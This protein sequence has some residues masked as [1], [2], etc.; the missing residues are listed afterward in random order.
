MIVVIADD[1]SG[2]A[3][4]AGTAREAGLS[5]EVQTEFD[6]SSPAEV[7]AVDTDSRAS[8]EADAIAKVSAIAR[9]VV[10]A[11]PAWIYK[12]CD[13][14]LRG[15]VLAEC[16][17]IATVADKQRVLLI[18]ANPGRQRVIRDGR[19]LVSGV[20][21]DQS[22]FARDPQ[23]PARTADVLANL[24]EKRDGIYSLR[25]TKAPHADGVSIPDVWESL[26]L[27]ERARQ[28]GPETL[29]AGAME[30]FTAL[31]RRTPL[32]SGTAPEFETRSPLRL[33]A[34]GSHA[35]WAGTRVRECQGR[36]VPIVPMPRRIFEEDFEDR[37]IDQ[38]ADETVGAFAIGD[39]VMIA[40]GGEKISGLPPGRLDSRLADA[41]RR[42]LNRVTIGQLCLEGGAT[43]A[44]VLGRCGWKR[45]QVGRA[46]APGLARLQVLNNP[47]PLVLIKP[48]SYPWPDAV[49]D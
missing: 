27:R 9:Q 12:K 31:L 28:V 25:P 42:V 35:A 10:A 1:L 3:E 45:L 33:F 34:C 2:A 15:H 8:N 5:A 11:K 44:S 21:L 7:I 16:R 13:S 36:G 4:L 24:S 26:H 14:V 38:W 19:Y 6:P 20:P 48:G 29:A 17:A 23:H 22:P 49:W 39:R 41:V 46:I 30:F 18:P 40:I 47:A 32:R 43:A 37:E